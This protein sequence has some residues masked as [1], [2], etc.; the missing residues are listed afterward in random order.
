MI[1]L[2]AKRG[3]HRTQAF[4]V[5]NSFLKALPKTDRVSVVAVDLQSAPVSKGMVTADENNI[6]QIM[7]VLNRRV[8]LGATNLYAALSSAVEQ[9]DGKRPASILYIGD[10]MSTANLMGSDEL[11][12]LVQ[13]L[14]SRKIPVHSYAVGPRTDLELLGLLGQLTGGRVLYDMMEKDSATTAGKQLAVAVDAPIF[15]PTK[16]NLDASF[17]SVMPAMALPIRTDRE[18]VYLA[19]GTVVW[20]S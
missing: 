18:T 14:R 2:P 20:R 9:F 8:P 3:E 15:F 6:K 1:P 17:K 16:I 4:G 13:S 12:E 5:L 19:K 10:G 11:Q 7:S